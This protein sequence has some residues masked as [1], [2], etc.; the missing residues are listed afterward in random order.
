MFC[1][2]ISFQGHAESLRT[3]TAFGPSDSQTGPG[4]QGGWA[5]HRP[6]SLAVAM[7]GNFQGVPI[8]EMNFGGSV[9]RMNWVSLALVSCHAQGLPGHSFFSVK[10]LSFGGCCHHDVT[11]V[12]GPETA[13]LQDPSI[14]FPA[15]AGGSCTQVLC[16]QRE[17]LV[18]GSSLTHIP[19]YRVSSPQE[20]SGG[21]GFTPCSTKDRVKS[22]KL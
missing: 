11:E 12:W 7:T 13:C 19:C 17:S 1:R 22:L 10:S 21:G 16:P 3:R 18:V 15:R 5:N 14:D 20:G 2:E 4:I 6:V 9:Y 8:S